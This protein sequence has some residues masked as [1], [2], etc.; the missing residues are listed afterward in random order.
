MTEPQV[1]GNLAVV[2]LIDASADSHRD[3][4]S[5]DLGFE[6]DKLEVAE[7]GN[8]PN[9]NFSTSEA[10][11]IRL[12]E[13]VVEGGRQDRIVAESRII[14]GHNRVKV[15][16]IERDRWHD[17]S[18]SWTRIDTPVSLRRA[19]M[20]GAGQQQVWSRV[21][22]ILS[23]WGVSSN[24][25]ALSAIYKHLGR[26]F[27]RRAMKFSLWDDQVGMIV[28]I[29]DKVAG[30]EYFGDKMSFSRE[31]YGILQRSYVPDAFQE[32]SG[33]LPEEDVVE[34]VENFLDELRNNRRAAEVVQYNNQ[35]V[36]AHA[37]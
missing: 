26:Q 8:V 16:C 22:E 27:E 30:M 15:F 35:V 3:L 1:S 21:N 9:L 37:V 12:G 36:Y 6:M 5:M 7:T 29:N 17:Q 23:Y 10:T 19:V 34:S 2:G 24:T 28:V 4:L 18:Q 25:R 13:A 31:G 14:E 11:L 32:E 20:N 33:H